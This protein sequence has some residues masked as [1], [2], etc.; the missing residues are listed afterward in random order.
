M[1]FGLGKSGF[2]DLIEIRWPSRVVDRLEKIEANQV[3]LVEEGSS[4]ENVEERPA[5]KT[6]DQER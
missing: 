3:I 2:A 4:N 6:S 1:H 5:S